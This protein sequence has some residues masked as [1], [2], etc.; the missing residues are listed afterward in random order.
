MSPDLADAMYEHES[1][2][3][4][5]FD[6]CVCDAIQRCYEREDKTMKIKFTAWI[7]V[8]RACWT[9]S[10]IDWALRVLCPGEH[11]AQI[12]SWCERF[13]GDYRVTLEER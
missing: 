10:L 11:L 12:A 7:N 2:C 6:C 1:S 5:V 13:A 8:R 9:I 4:R 3:D